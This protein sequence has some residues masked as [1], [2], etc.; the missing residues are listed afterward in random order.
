M[1]TYARHYKFSNSCSAWC[2]LWKFEQHPFVVKSHA[3]IRIAL[4]WS[5]VYS[6][7]HFQNTPVQRQAVNLTQPAVSCGPT[8][9]FPLIHSKV[10]LIPFTP[11]KGNLM[12][13]CGCK[14]ELKRFLG[15]CTQQSDSH[16]TRETSMCEQKWIHCWSIFLVKLLSHATFLLQ[17]NCRLQLFSADMKE[18][19]T[20]YTHRHHS[21]SLTSPSLNGTN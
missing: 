10:E 21:T 16:S 12:D 14:P 8:W 6:S 17:N 7:L 5:G 1:N 15:K 3:L 13:K 9:P 2:C 4:L 18:K 11:C 19:L 20:Q